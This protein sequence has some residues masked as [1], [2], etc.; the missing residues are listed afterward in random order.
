MTSIV[1]VS[2]LLLILTLVKHVNEMM[3]VIFLYRVSHKSHSKQS[4]SFF[5]EMRPER[6]GMSSI[7]TFG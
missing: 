7:T 5:R 3:T 6:Q 1:P 4:K 2:K